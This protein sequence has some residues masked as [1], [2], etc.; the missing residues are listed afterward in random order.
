MWQEVMQLKNLLYQWRIGVILSHSSKQQPNESNT[1][2]K[3]KI[4]LEE[5][6]HMAVVKKIWQDC[7]LI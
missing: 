6:T 1:S 7:G 2:N 5:E 4:N 3:Q